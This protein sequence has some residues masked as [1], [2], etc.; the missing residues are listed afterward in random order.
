MRS[1]TTFMAALAF[2]MPAAAQQ[3][4]LLTA[5]KH[6]EYGLVYTLPKTAVRID[7]TAKRSVEKAGPYYQYAKKF[8]GT[9]KVV[10]H[11]SERWVITDVRVTPYGISDDK[12]RYLMQLKNGQTTFMSV[13]DDGMLLAINKEVM[14]PT[15]PR[16]VESE[17]AGGTIK[18]DINEYLQFV[19]EDFIASQSSA[20]QAQMLAEGLME[21]RD[22]KMS[23]TRGT[24]E[25]RPTDGKQ[26]ELMLKSLERQER[27]MMAAFVGMSDSEIV[28]RSF[29]VVPEEDGQTVLFRLSDFAGFVG[30]DDYSGAPVYL[31]I[32]KT[33]QPKLPVDAKGEE[34][35][36]PKD[37]VMYTLPGTARISLSFEGKT[38]Y[39]EEMEMGQF[40]LRFG[41]DP[42][43]FTS[44]KERSYAVFNPVTGGVSQIGE[45]PA[46]GK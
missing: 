34:K 21:A 3:T 31:I 29:T 30:A 41:L 10:K 24:S 39:S 35:K 46:D 7:V 16:A 8:I 4:K 14:A 45:L 18:L 1:I 19:N 20:K 44:K 40:G 5:E 36:L 25:Q 2:L 13:A 42:K 32:E 37:A 27:A 11:D 43:L 17:S 23:L 22:S 28:E 33:Q 12:Q 26:L 15:Q 6:N 38:L 9:D